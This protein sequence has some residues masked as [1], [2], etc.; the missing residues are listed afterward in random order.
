MVASAAATGAVM[1]A[2]AV[3]EATEAAAIIPVVLEISAVTCGVRT[4]SVSVWE[5]TFAHVCKQNE[6]FGRSGSALW[7]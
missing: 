2:M 3:T 1:A 5:E 4:P 7:V 6:G